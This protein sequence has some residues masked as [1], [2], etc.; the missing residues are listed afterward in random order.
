MIFEAKSLEEAYTKASKHFNV[1]VSRLEINVIQNP[2]NGLFGLFAKNAIIEV[3]ESS[4]DL[5]VAKKVSENT[6][7]KADE[8][9]KN[10][11]KQEIQTNTKNIAQH[12]TTDSD[13]L[14]VPSIEEVV[15]IARKE[16]NEL[17]DLS[18]FSINKVEVTKYNDETILFEITGED[19]A[20]LIGKEG[21]RY[22]A[23][24]TMIF[25]WISQKYGYKTRLEIAS[26]LK[27]QE[28]MMR[29]FL[30]PTIEEIEEKGRCKTRPFD[31]VLAYIAVDILREK[32]PDKYVAIKK[33]RF[34]ESYIIV[35]Q[36]L[37]KND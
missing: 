11:T 19:A 30:E 1:S 10:I 2:S 31:G 32:F 35:N 6:H 22:N 5:S 37:N 23:L 8:E 20:L 4:S 15:D 33:N 16:I 24:S 28:E 13:S 26:F 7:N 9:Q 25:S 3:I 17:F 27:N 34:G 29:K 18:C 14:D 36:F 12:K 21:Y